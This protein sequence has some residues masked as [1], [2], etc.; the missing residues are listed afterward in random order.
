MSSETRGIEKPQK[1]KPPT[2]K[3]IAERIHAHLQ[4]MENARR[5]TGHTKTTR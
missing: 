2:L 3:Q 5:S 1:V 4:R